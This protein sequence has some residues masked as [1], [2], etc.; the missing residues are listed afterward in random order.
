MK[1]HQAELDIDLELVRRLVAQ[2]PRFSDLPL[3][4]LRSTGT[5]NAIY[6]LGDRYGVRLPRPERQPG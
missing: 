1:L 6:R 2:L 5:V 3:Q 4:K